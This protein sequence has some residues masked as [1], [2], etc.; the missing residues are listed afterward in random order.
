MGNDQIAGNRATS[1]ICRAARLARFIN[2]PQLATN[3]I[4]P[5]SPK[6]NPH[7]LTRN[8]TN[9]FPPRTATT[10]P[11]QTPATRTCAAATTSCLRTSPS[12]GYICCTPR[13]GRNGASRT[14][15]VCRRASRSA[16]PTARRR[17][18]SM[19]S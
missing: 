1:S 7:Q 8:P 4:P 11:T 13:R 16:I 12:R 5:H 10:Q 18:M 6:K 19:A 14:T 9:T 15:C 2:P 17:R 3:L